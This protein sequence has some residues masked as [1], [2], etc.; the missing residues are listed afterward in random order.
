MSNTL[1]DSEILFIDNWPDGPIINGPGPFKGPVSPPTGT[2][3]GGGVAA[4]GDHNVLL[5]G[6][7]VGTKW[8]S[9]QPSATGQTQGWS[10][11]IYL[12]V[13][14]QEASIAAKSLVMLETM[15]S[16]STAGSLLYTVTNDDATANMDTGLAA[17]AIG[18]MTDGYCGWFWCGGVCPV[19]ICPSLGGTHATNGAVVIGFMEAVSSTVIKFGTWTDNHCHVAIAICLTATDVA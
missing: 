5:P 12:K 18:A 13:G 6:H 10:T 1:D 11:W 9:Y 2:P 15:P 4:G 17:M 7:D 19:S 16:S 8:F 14:T 3:T